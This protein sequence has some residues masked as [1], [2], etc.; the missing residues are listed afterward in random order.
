M[1]DVETLLK[2]YGQSFLDK[3]YDQV[4]WAPNIKIV[5]DR[6]VMNSKLA[7]SHMGNPRNIR[8]GASEVE[9]L[10]LFEAKATNAPVHIFVH[11]GA[12]RDG[13]ANEY[14]FLA[15]APLAM[16]AHVLVPNFANVLDTGGDLLP[17][18][19]QVARSIAW[20]YENA[21]SYGGDRTRIY[22]S[23]HSSGAHL[24]AVAL[25]RDWERDFGVPNDVIKGA[26]LVSGLYDLKAA[27]LSSRSNYVRFDDDVEQRLSPQRHLDRIQAPL[28]VVHGTNESPEFIRQ[29]Q[30]FAQ[31][32]ASKGK[33]VQLLTAAG[34][35]HLEVLETLA[36][37]FGLAGRAALAQMMSS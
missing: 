18:A 24:A 31:V 33:H 8:Y 26:V 34:Y 37:P 1:T 20:A 29:S 32:A 11:G 25:T 35:N 30:E 28:V 16:G 22:L 12:W 6:F 5:L 15:E 10:D 7:R 9:N 2:S 23:A 27:R 19:E 3:A 21:P 14:S 13:H 4:N 17:M 36:S